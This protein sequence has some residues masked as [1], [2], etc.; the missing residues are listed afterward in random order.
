MQAYRL[1]TAWP[2]MHPQDRNAMSAA[3]IIKE[4]A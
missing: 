2:R 4:N 1:V 3:H